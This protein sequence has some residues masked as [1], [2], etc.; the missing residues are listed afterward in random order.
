MAESHSAGFDLGRLPSSTFSYHFTDNGEIM[1]TLLWLYALIAFW[2]SG[3]IFVSRGQTGFGGIL[4]S[5][6]AGL[7]WPFGVVASLVM[8]REV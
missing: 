4:R 3:A 8:W 2:W 5:F 7:I 6:L 1:T